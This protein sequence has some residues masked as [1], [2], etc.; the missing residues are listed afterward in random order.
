MSKEVVWRKYR[1]WSGAKV[2]G[3][4]K[5]VLTSEEASQHLY[6]A[7]YLTSL[8][9]GG[10]R[11]GTVQS[12][13]GVGMS[14]GLEH[15]IAIYPKTMKQGS[16]WKLLRDLEVHAPSPAL[17]KLWLEFSDNGVYV[18]Q[19][20]LLRRKIDGSIVSARSI[21]DIFTPLGGKVPKTGRHWDTSKKW[22]LLFHELFEHKSTHKTQISSAISY[23]LKGNKKVEL[24]SY[25]K[26]TNVQHPSAATSTN[27]SIEH[28]LAW[29]VYH[30]FSVNA[31]TMARRRLQASN[32]N[33]SNSWP[34]RLIK[35]LGIT[36]YGNWKDDS[37]GRSRYDRTRSLAIKSKLWPEYLFAGP[38]AIMPANI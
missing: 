1:S 9:E 27:I 22:A 24:G 38:S 34:K 17:Q 32:P 31:P 14:A 33:S 6:R 36:D 37:T 7:L 19:D 35:T 25:K 10:A 15:K 30:S 26:T 21:R 13:D 20:S 8:V 23:L 12:F 3:G 11:F 16:L 2:V 29:C 5:F 18:S 4:V 28:D